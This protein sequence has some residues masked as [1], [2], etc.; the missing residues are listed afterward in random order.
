MGPSGFAL[1]AAGVILAQAGALLL[2]RRRFGR[3]LGTSLGAVAVGLAVGAL[4][5]GLVS[6]LLRHYP[7]FIGLR[8]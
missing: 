8:L 7:S 6:A 2:A 4:G 5:A 1:V 3:R